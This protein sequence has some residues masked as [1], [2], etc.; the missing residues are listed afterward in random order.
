MTDRLIDAVSEKESWQGRLQFV[1]QVRATTEY[2]EN[3]HDSTG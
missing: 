3:R 2:C 1:D